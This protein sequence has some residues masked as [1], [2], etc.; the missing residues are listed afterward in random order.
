MPKDARF[1]FLLNPNLSS[2]FIMLKWNYKRCWHLDFILLFLTRLKKE[3]DQRIEQNLG[4]NVEK[5]QTKFYKNHSFDACFNQYKTLNDSR[6]LKCYGE[7][8]LTKFDNLNSPR[9]LQWHKQK[10]TFTFAFACASVFVS[11]PHSSSHR[12]FRNKR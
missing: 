2:F 10:Y 4:K 6:C 3:Q 8:E 9:R 12:L 11:S 1:N 7:D 5:R